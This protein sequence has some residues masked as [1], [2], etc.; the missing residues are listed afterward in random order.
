MQ[1]RYP[2]VGGITPEH[3]FLQ[4]FLGCTDELTAR[5][6]SDRFREVQYCG[7][8]QPGQTAQYLES[9]RLYTPDTGKHIPS[10]SGKLRT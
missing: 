5:F 9:H 4:L 7:G 2:D 3:D 8:I 1:V 10:G 6:I